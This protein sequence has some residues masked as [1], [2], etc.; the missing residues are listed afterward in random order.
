MSRVPPLDPATL[1]AE[2][3]RV[4]AAIAGA[5]K[6]VR[7]PFT[8]WLR[9]P[10]AREN[11]WFGIAALLA[12]ADVSISFLPW[13]S[14]STTTLHMPEMRIL[15]AG[16]WF[17]AI[18]WFGVEYS[19][20]GQDHRRYALLATVLIAGA[21]S[22]ELFSAGVAARSY[23]RVLAALPVAILFWLV[24]DGALRMWDSARRVRTCG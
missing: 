10:A 22:A 16:G 3:Q 23:V 19:A 6:N 15:L 18:T 14:S 24:A 7:G 1:T 17:V 20:S 11:F 2:Q 12:A 5:R 4:A 8:I 13:S 9:N 21:C